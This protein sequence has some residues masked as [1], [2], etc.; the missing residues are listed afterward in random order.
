MSLFLYYK[1]K[2]EIVNNFFNFTQQKILRYLIQIKKMK[3]F[4]ATIK[5]KY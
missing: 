3:L 2:N 1:D 5:I 4:Y